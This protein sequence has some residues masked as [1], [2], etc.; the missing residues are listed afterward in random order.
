MFIIHAKMQIQP[1]KV[2]SFLNEIN[3]L[4]KLSQ[5]EEGNISY[6]LMRST[7]EENAFMMVEE[8]KDSEA[9]EV[10]NKS[11]HFNDFVAKAPE[12][13]AAPMEVKVFQS[14]KIN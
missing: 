8:W 3:E 14:E 13:F 1:G 11:A 5:A 2:D 10:H 6:E 4:I 12:Y 7:S 9:I